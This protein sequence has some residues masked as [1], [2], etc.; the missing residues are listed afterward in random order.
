MI[1]PG[2]GLPFPLVTLFGPGRAKNQHRKINDFSNDQ[3]S[4]K[5]A[6][7]IDPVPPKVRF[8]SKNQDFRVSFWHSF[9]DIFPKWRKCVISEEYNAKRGSEP[10]K[11]F[12][13]R[14]GF[15]LIVHVFFPNPLSESIFG[16]SRCQPMLKNLIL[17]S[18]WIH[19][20]PKTRT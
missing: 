5:I 13:C 14:V 15:S 7:S 6:K 12:D 3:K 9:F 19:G 10:S 4:T 16:G 17:V 20:R 18:F 8:W 11:T 2:R 1:G